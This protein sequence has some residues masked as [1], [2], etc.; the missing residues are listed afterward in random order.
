MTTD[1]VGRTVD[2][3]YEPNPKQALAHSVAV[4]ELL[5]G[6]A[7]GGGKVGRCPDRAA[8]SY[9]VSMETKVLTPKGFVLLGDVTVGQ[10]VCNPDGTVATVIALHH[11]RNQ[12]FYR[13]TLADGASV[14][15]GGDHLWAVRARL[16]RKRRK[17]PLG[18]VPAGL[19]AAEEWNHRYYQR[20]TV[21]TTRQMH[22]RIHA[23]HGL[24]LP[25]TAPVRL[26]SPPGRWP[27]L[28]PYTMGALL[29]DGSFGKVSTTITSVD[30]EVTDAIK[31]ELAPLSLTLTHGAN[32]KRHAL[33]RVTGLE[34]DPEAAHHYVRRVGL[35]GVRSDTKFIPRSYL[36]APTGD[37]LAL[38]QGLFDTDGY[39]D[40]RGHV[41]Y[42]T[43]SP[44][45]A[46]DVQWLL[47]SLGF[48]AKISN[49]KPG[50]YVN[51]AGERVMCKTVYRIYV[52]GNGLGRLFLLPRKV[53]RARDVIGA[54]SAAVG[55]Q[56]ADNPIVSIE[57]TVVEDGRCITVD[58]PNGLYVTD[59][60][61]VTH[62]SR[63]ARVE[64]VAFLLEIPGAAAVLF[65]RSFPDLSRADGPIRSLRE[66][67][68]RELG[69]YNANDRLWTFHNG[70]TLELAHLGRDEDVTKYQGAAYQLIVWEEATQ[71]TEYQFL[72]MMS[73][74]RAAGSV[75]ALMAAK[76]I[77]PRVILTTNPGGVGHAWVKA[78]YVDPYPAGKAWRP[79]P[80][81]DD[82]NPGTRLFIPAYVTDNPH[83]DPG[84]IDRLN[85]LDPDTRRALRDGD[86][87]VYAGQRFRHFRRDIHVI[88]PEELPL[89][90]GGT[91]RGVGV[92][93][94]L[95][96]PFCALWGAVLPDGLV[97]VYR[98]L[99]QAGLTAAQQADAIADAEVEGER[100]PRR[101]R[102]IPIALDPSTWARS[103]HHPASVKG[104]G[105]TV[106]GID[107]DTPPPGSIAAAY[108][109]VFGGEVVKAR[110]DRL[111][112]VAGVSDKLRVRPDGLPRL[113]IYST[114][115]NLI[116]TLPAL[117]RDPRRVED[118]DTR[119]EDHAFDALK[120]LLNLLESS[121]PARAAAGRRRRRD[122]AEA[123]T[124]PA[125]VRA[126]TAGLA[127]RPL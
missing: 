40:A 15:A 90:L 58:N 117:P 55:G 57:A 107:P 43:V 100:L 52:R 64:A 83:V 106:G 126:D 81:A 127:R 86:W 46:A 24:A 8:P 2:L 124:A 5:Y 16:G 87:D 54:G 33:V 72:Y 102:P 98:E 49:G 76:D 122:P 89:S 95:D 47:R 61:I 3:G 101:G 45:L 79:A 73:R 9:D 20:Y 75:A 12:Q 50:S 32:G 68:P 38:A 120:Y 41:E 71:F 125:G 42:V 13:V 21:M 18:E 84:Y 69:T 7:A 30:P 25:L 56:W 22:D 11:P 88:E 37:R 67:I 114:C 93:Y 103:P 1:P 17:V 118:V 65:R 116:R 82:P 51:G 48:T 74:L 4:D 80:N 36:Q 6:G 112:G 29:G 109:D 19:T 111:A 44:R 77:T 63:F 110:N 92:D 115:R 28:P 99:Y 27:V 123:T 10:Q 60:F 59:D 96:A 70:S 105:V 121:A 108:T 66:E 119:A 78:R 94:G 14:E 35:A 104:P 85:R 23:G 31:A 26:T 91:P 62:N 39:V 53:A 97:V 113:L 34:I